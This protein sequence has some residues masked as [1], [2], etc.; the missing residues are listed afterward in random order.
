MAARHTRDLGVAR[1]ILEL[2]DV[3][4]VAMTLSGGCWTVH[5]AK[6]ELGK[7]GHVIVIHTPE[8]AP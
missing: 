3:R 1:L 2:L 6:L 7:R 5:Y 8:L 4:A